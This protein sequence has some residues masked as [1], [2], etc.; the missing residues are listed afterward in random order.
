MLR[1]SEMPCKARKIKP[2]NGKQKGTCC[3]CGIK[4]NNGHEKKFKN[5]FT[6]ADLVSS[7]DVICPECYHL[8]LNSDEYRRTMYIVTENEY[9]PFKKGEMV[10]IIFNLP[11]IPF[12]LY[13]TKTWQKVG[14]VR[15]NQ[16]PNTGQSTNINFL[17]DYNII[18]CNI[19]QLKNLYDFGKLFHHLKI[20]KNELETGNI[21]LNSLNKLKEEYGLKKAYK[22]VEQLKKHATNPVW[23]LT[24]YML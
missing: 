1:F 6:T 20:S 2:E 14:W 5:N 9:K 12:Y 15:M 11:N 8:V 19:K 4:T 10:D 13:L 17:I 22:M 23:D 3:I 24:V 7:G 18:S 16:V 21:N